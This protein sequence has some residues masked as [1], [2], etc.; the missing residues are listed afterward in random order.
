MKQFDQ[1]FTKNPEELKGAF[2]GNCNRT[3]CQQPGAVWY[4]HSTEAYY[5]SKCAKLINDYNRADSMRLFGHELCTLVKS[6][7]EETI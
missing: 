3:A 4:N 6:E 5:C 7:D 1:N 2:N